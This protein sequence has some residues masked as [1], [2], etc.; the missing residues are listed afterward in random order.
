MK[1]ATGL[2]KTT[3]PITLLLGTMCG[4]LKQA[5]LQVHALKYVLKIIIVRAHGF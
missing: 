2:H 5:Y 4:S 1:L 3:L